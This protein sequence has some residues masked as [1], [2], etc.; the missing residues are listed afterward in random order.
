MQ[1]PIYAPVSTGN[2]SSTAS[3]RQPQGLYCGGKGGAAQGVAHTQLK[4]NFC[5]VSADLNRS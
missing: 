2:R 3:E 1:R 4:S 5:H